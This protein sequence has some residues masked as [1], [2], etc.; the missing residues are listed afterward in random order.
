MFVRLKVKVLVSSL[1][2]L[3]KS[4]AREPAARLAL[5][6]ASNTDGKDRRIAGRLILKICA[7]SNPK[8]NTGAFADDRPS[9]SSFVAILK[10]Y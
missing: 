5:N 3:A 1:E 7:R 6:A 10:A 9:P 8:R 4:G 2:E